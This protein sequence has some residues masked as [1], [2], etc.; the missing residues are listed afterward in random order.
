MQSTPQGTTPLPRSQ[1]HRATAN[2]RSQS[3]RTSCDQANV[4]ARNSK[5]QVRGRIQM[6]ESKRGSGKAIERF[7]R[8]RLTPPRRVPP[9]PPPTPR[10][11]QSP[12]HSPLLSLSRPP[13]FSL[14]LAP[15]RSR[16][17][18]LSLSRSPRPAL[19]FRHLARLFA[20]LSIHRSTPRYSSRFRVVYS[21][22]S[23]AD[24][25]AVLRTSLHGAV[26]VLSSCCVPFREWRALRSL[27]SRV[28]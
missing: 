5:A 22:F 11:P 20:W 25:L 1:T 3:T 12:T 23:R 19:V 27:C 28:L 26:L 8:H 15:S 2:S 14:T 6:R 4:D 10:V 24:L 21:L 13:L 18:A 16:S 17:R 7:H 9:S